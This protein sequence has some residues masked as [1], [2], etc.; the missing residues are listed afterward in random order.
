MK[1]HCTYMEVEASMSPKVSPNTG[2]ERKTAGAINGSGRFTD[3]DEQLGRINGRSDCIDER[4]IALNAAHRENYLELFR[5]ALS[6]IGS[7]ELA[8][9]TV[10][11][12]FANTLSTVE[13]GRPVHNIG[14]FLRRCVRNICLDHIKQEHPLSLEQDVPDNHEPSFLTERSTGSVVE[15]RDECRKIEGIIDDLPLNQRSV[16]LLVELRGLGY[17]EVADI[18]NS[19]VDSVRQMLYRARQHVRT[20]VGNGSEWTGAFPALG[21]DRILF[22]GREPFLERSLAQIKE[23]VFGA[24][25]WFGNFVQQ[26]IEPA[27]QPASFV[28]GTIAI[29]IA[30]GTLGPGSLEP[31]PVSTPN[32]TEHADTMAK[33]PIAG[34]DASMK[35]AMWEPTN[36]AHRAPIDPASGNNSDSRIDTPTERG[37]TDSSELPNADTASKEGLLDP[38]SDGAEETNEDQ[39][40]EETGVPPEGIGLSMTPPGGN[41]F[42][43]H[44]LADPELSTGGN[45]AQIS[46]LQDAANV[47][48]DHGSQPRNEENMLPSDPISRADLPADPSGNDE[49]DDTGFVPDGTGI[50][51]DPST[52]A[53]RHP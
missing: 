4:V 33:P 24:Q 50:D 3:G 17:D 23:K 11:Q 41:E 31:G 36:N 34:S 9:D 15:I 25:S 45:G 37:P 52:L 12:A 44:A 26:T 28:V 19:S 1:K 47:E 30:T 22:P 40:D 21:A 42:S 10:Q 32:T 48:I 18:L 51:G 2:Q 38:D 43:T 7:Q 14:G 35:P 46:R 16:F 39:V 5:Y 29:V 53:P 6:M 27:L 49:S 8:H 20:T 13:Q